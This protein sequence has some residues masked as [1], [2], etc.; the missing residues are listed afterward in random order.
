MWGDDAM[1]EIYSELYYY[2]YN[3]ITDALLALEGGNT[4]AARAVLLEAQQE[5]ED[6]YIASQ[7]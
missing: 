1:K 6:K 3:R 5:A 4:D 2:L 7:E